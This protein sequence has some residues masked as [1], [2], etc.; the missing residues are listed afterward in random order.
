M[1][2]LDDRHPGRSKDEVTQSIGRARIHM[3]PASSCKRLVSV[4][5]DAR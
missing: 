1:E 5:S 2:D 3:V 4:E